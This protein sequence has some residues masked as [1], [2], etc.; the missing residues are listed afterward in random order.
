MMTSRCVRS[1]LTEGLLLAISLGGVLAASAQQSD[2][3]VTSR[4]LGADGTPAAPTF[5]FFNEPTLG[6]HRPGPGRGQFNSD[7]T[8][9]NPC[10]NTDALLT[11][12]GLRGDT[13]GH[14]F[15][16]THTQDD[17]IAPHFLFGRDGGLHITHYLM[18]SNDYWVGPPNWVQPELFDGTHFV[19]STIAAIADQTGYNT[20]ATF[21]SFGLPSYRGIPV[22]R[23]S[24]YQGY[25]SAEFSAGRGNGRMTGKL[26]FDVRDD[27]AIQLGG[28]KFADLP[29]DAPN[30]TMY[31]CE[32]CADPS[33]ICTGGGTGAFAKRLNGRWRCS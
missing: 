25:G 14:W 1:V 24:L 23:P 22:T 33:Y 28:K 29:D 6:W 3:I 20:A 9:C 10:L 32:D 4:F 13:T 15:K 16:I 12:R 8:L 18:A 11:I 26:V 5:S 17:S 30:G 19:A 31:F 7:G 21:V 27:G 2:G